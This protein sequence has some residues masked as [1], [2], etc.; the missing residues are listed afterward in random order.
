MQNKMFKNYFIRV[1]QINRNLCESVDN[2]VRQNSVQTNKTTVGITSEN[3][4]KSL[5]SDYNNDMNC[6]KRLIGFEERRAFLFIEI[7]IVFKKKISIFL[8][9]IVPQ[10]MANFGQNK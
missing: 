2:V 7:K 4:E 3:N 10:H 9:D 6:Q 1:I 5:Y 8:L